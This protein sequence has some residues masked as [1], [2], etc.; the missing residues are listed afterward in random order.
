LIALNPHFVGQ[1]HISFVPHDEAPMNF[2]VVPFTR[3]RWIMLLGYPLDLKDF[4][5]I[6]HA[7]A[8]FAR[9]LHWNSDDASLARVILKVFVEDPM[10][11][12]RSLV[13]KM[14][15][16]SNGHGRSWIAPVYVFNSNLVNVGPTDE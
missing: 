13:L 11:I 5:T 3:K 12:P 8:P 10:E 9:V 14:G 15:R 7:C 16:E 6:T 1:R 4:A 2:R